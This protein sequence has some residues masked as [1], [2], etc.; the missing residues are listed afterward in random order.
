MVESSTQGEVGQNMGADMHKI[1]FVQHHKGISLVVDGDDIP[2]V[3]EIE[4]VD[5]DFEDVN[6]FEDFEAN[7]EFE[8]VKGCG[9]RAKIS[10]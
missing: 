2:R 6:P 4:P 7:I 1:R 3:Y 5:G 10:R 9:F 8:W